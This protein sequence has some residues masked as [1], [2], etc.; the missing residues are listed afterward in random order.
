MSAIAFLIYL[1]HIKRHEKNGSVTNKYCVTSFIY[2]CAG[3][4]VLFIDEKQSS[5]QL[6]P[7][8]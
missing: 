7:K 4:A 1:T 3:T 2:F 8:Q 6:S 5:G